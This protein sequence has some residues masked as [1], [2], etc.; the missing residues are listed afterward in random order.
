MVMES[1]LKFSDGQLARTSV[2][3]RLAPVNSETINPKAPRKSVFDRLTTSTEHP[4]TDAPQH[5]NIDLPLDPFN[6]EE[7][8]EKPA[9]LPR[10]PK[11]LLIES[12]K[13]KLE[14]NDKDISNLNRKLDEV[15]EM[16]INMQTHMGVQLRNPKVQVIPPTLNLSTPSTEENRTNQLVTTPRIQKDTHNMTIDEISELI[17]IQLKAQ[18]STSFYPSRARREDEKEAEAKTTHSR[19]A[20]ANNIEKEKK[21]NTSV[22]PTS[23]PM[24]GGGTYRMTMG[25]RKSKVYSF[26]ETK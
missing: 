5:L 15:L 20:Y 2:F 24:L 23:K 22:G 18:I 16:V 3:K 13:K 11:D 4:N 6:M 26:K 25:K 9:F 12:I 21:P 17:A 8:E 19:T 14:E 7:N 1:R 10:N